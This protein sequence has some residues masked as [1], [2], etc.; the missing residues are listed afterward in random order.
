M[1]G[2]RQL[3]LLCFVASNMKKKKKKKRKKNL[4]TC[5]LGKNPGFCVI[6]LNAV[7]RY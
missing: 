6:L 2:S 3:C 1:T 5:S 7:L 4:K